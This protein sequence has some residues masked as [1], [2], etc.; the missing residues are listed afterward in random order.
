MTSTAADHATTHATIVPA[1]FWRRYAAYSLDLALLGSLATV[2]TWSQLHAGWQETRAAMAALSSRI[3]QALADALM[4]GTTAMEVSQTLLHDTGMA[5][6]VDALHAGLGHML[7][8]WLWCYVVLAAL[9]HVGGELSRWQGSPGKHA[10]Q[11]AVAGVDGRPLSLLRAS[12]RHVA[13]ALSWLTLNLGH[14]LA[15]LPPHKRALH[16]YIAGARV[17]VANGDPRLPGWAAAWIAIQVIAGFALLGW[18][19]LR[20]VAALQATALG[21]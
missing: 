10:M 8:P 6:A 21:I 1:G 19:L 2:L 9:W 11:L 20:Y 14:L 17:V 5:T 15:A 4:S 7:W 3:G 12:V 18:L 16:D 13:G